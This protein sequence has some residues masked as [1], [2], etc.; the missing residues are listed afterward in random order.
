MH[1]GNDEDADFDNIIKYAP[2]ESD[3]SRPVGNEPSENIAD[4]AKIVKALQCQ[5]CDFVS[6]SIEVL[7]QHF[8]AH[9]ISTSPTDVTD[10]SNE[11]V[12]EIL[13]CSLCY[14]QYTSL[15]ILRNHMITDHGCTEKVQKNSTLRPS[16]S[17]SPMDREGCNADVEDNKSEDSVS[18]SEDET[19][20]VSFKDFKLRLTRS[21]I[22]K[23]SVKGCFYKFESREKQEQHLQC[24]C[25]TEADKV[26]DFKCTACTIDLKTWRNCSSH[27]WKE[28]KK[29]VDLLKCPI[30]TYKAITAVKVWRHMRVHGRWRS[31]VLKR[32]H[33]NKE[34]KDKGII[35]WYTQKTCEIC[36]RI[37]A[38]SRTLS[39]HVKTVHNR[40]KPFICNVCGRKS[41]RKSTWIVHMRQHTGERPYQ[42]KSC[43]FKASDPSVLKKHEMRH[44][45]T[46]SYKCNLCEYSAI[47]S[48]SFKNHMKLYH[49]EEFK[50][51]LC[52][53]C[54]YISVN[55]D[56]LEAHKKDHKKGLI[57]NEDS[58]EARITTSSLKITTNP[59]AEKPTGNVEISSDCFLPLES[60]DSIAHDPSIDTGGVT[61]PAHS[62]DT[63]F[64]PTF[65]HP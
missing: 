2:E 4:I 15:E 24:H 47:Q 14:G 54:N 7:L 51:I 29:D 65:M 21:L 57:Q 40:I 53:Q 60:T 38:N 30:C 27:M 41:A 52:D 39:K 25:S 20:P 61:I 17:S 9:S 3:D 11:S 43:L 36:S 46:S 49:P 62:E 8:K 12:E 33:V 10:N 59:H 34:N 6:S 44:S 63:Q 32:K 13:V 23:C 31:K 1:S 56:I 55:S 19:A 18:P 50:K 48:S 22:Y 45:N 26:R 5:K 28:H 37:F 16:K 35:R 42:C 64:P 58:S